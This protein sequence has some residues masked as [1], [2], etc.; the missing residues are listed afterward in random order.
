MAM[1]LAIAAYAL[2][3]NTIAF[4]LFA[5][6]KRRA[7]YG[8][9]RISESTL[10]TAAAIGGS[11][12][13]LIASSTLHHKTRKEPFRTRLRLIVILQT[14]AL[15]ALFVPQVREFVGQLVSRTG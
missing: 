13:A 12:G 7:R 10:L 15:I 2:A 14:L 3:I 9:W 1:S 5:I 8:L 6:D 4:L 11:I